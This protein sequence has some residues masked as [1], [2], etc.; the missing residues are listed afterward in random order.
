MKRNQ[1]VGWCSQNANYI[2]LLPRADRSANDD[3]H[4][5]ADW[6]Y[7]Q[8]YTYPRSCLVKYVPWF[9]ASL[10]QAD[11]IGLVFLGAR[12]SEYFI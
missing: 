8:C 3:D 9:G 5:E 4:S 7:S 6:I 1:E 10:L 11:V 12:A 2:A